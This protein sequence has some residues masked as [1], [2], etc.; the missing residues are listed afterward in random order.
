MKYEAKFPIVEAIQ[1]DNSDKF[2]PEKIK[3]F[4][5][6]AGLGRVASIEVMQCG[7]DLLLFIVV[8]NSNGVYELEVFPG[9]YV[10][11]INNTFEVATKADFEELYKLID[12]YLTKSAPSFLPPDSKKDYIPDSNNRGMLL[13]IKEENKILENQIR[14][15]IKENKELKDKLQTVT[16]AEE[17]NAILQNRIDKLEKNIIGYQKYL[18]D[19]PFACTT[20]IGPASFTIKTK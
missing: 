11:K 14:A 9:D 10:I 19:N 12:L 15:L 4:I 16:L 8:I 5:N 13:V 6:T 7:D 17:N 18:I 1:F 20:T 2:S 3:D